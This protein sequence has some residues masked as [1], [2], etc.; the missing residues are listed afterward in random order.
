MNNSKIKRYLIPRKQQTKD[1][2]FNAVYDY[3]KANM[4][5]SFLAIINSIGILYFLIYF[6]NIQYIPNLDFAG[7]MYLL[8]VMTLIGLFTS[9][10]LYFL[11]ILPGLIWKESS[12]ILLDNKKNN[13]R[14]II[15]SPPNLGLFLIVYTLSAIIVIVIS[16]YIK[17]QKYTLLAY[18][19]SIFFLSLIIC[20]FTTQ[21]N[22]INI[23]DLKNIFFIVFFISLAIVFP[24]VGTYLIVPDKKDLIEIFIIFLSIGFITNIFIIKDKPYSVDKLRSFLISLFMF[25]IFLL[26]INPKLIPFLVVKNLHIGNFNATVV[27]KH[28]YCS[29]LK[30]YQVEIFDENSIS[31]S[32]DIKNVLWRVGKEALLEVP[33]KNITVPTDQIISMS[34]PKMKRVGKT[35]SSSFVPIISFEFNSTKLTK[36]G[37]KELMK[38]IEAL[39][40]NT[41][42][43]TVYGCASPEGTEKFNKRLSKHRAEKIQIWLEG[44]FANQ[45]KEVKVNVVAEGTSKYCTDANLI[46]ELENHRKV[47]I[48]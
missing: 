26:L 38:Q 37:K 33:D 46:E 29:T 18:F 39:D 7:L 48:K 23:K 13:F 42:E 3:S 9:I 43:V 17:E 47:I 12:S 28:D 34:W 45:G 5:S 11:F 4:I 16:L 36:S 40:A 20:L 1:T 27:F 19:S 31:C 25:F 10:F 30:N 35:N 2:L 14:I 15:T 32:A 8:V 6:F 21:L 44:Y 24:L 41:T 22:R